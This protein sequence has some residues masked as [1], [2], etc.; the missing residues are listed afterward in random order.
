MARLSPVFS[1]GLSREPVSL[2]APEVYGR[3]MD[4]MPEPGDLIEAFSPPA[5]PVLSHGAVTPPAGDPLQRGAGMEGEL[6]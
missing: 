1:A 2:S 5:R 3:P 6:A 4:R